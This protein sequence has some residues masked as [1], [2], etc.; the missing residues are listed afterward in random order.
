MVSLHLRHASPH[1]VARQPAADEDDEAVQPRDAVAAVGERFDLEVELLVLP[2]RRGHRDQ[3]R[4]ATAD[5]PWRQLP[6]DE[7]PARE[8]AGGRDVRATVA[9]EVS[10]GD[11][12]RMP[13]ERPA[14]VVD[15]E[16][17]EGAAPLLEHHSDR[18]GGPGDQVDLS[19]AA[20]VERLDSVRV[21]DSRRHR[22]RTEPPIRRLGEHLER[23]AVGGGHVQ[24]AV[25]RRSATATPEAPRRV[26]W[27]RARLKVPLRRWR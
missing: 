8:A 16:A 21:V 4:R 22:H 17:P 15:V 5:Q 26:R 25:A 20:Q 9:R 13:A 24:A 10:G 23:A 14:G 18:L 6:K 2:N 27:M 12:I 11:R 3:H 19:V 7:E 1:D